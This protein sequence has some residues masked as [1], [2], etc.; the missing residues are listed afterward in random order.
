MSN[1]GEK[2]NLGGMKECLVTGHTHLHAEKE[3]TR[4]LPIVFFFFPFLRSDNIS[5]GSV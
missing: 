1:L 2:N 3:D 4:P 5:F